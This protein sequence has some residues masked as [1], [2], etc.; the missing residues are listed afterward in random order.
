[1]PVVDVDFDVA[2]ASATRRDE[3]TASVAADLGCGGGEGAVWEADVEEAKVWGDG[4]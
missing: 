2:G 3:E 1:M 4:R